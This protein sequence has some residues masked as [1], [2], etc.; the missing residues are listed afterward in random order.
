MTQKLTILEDVE[1][2]QIEFVKEWEIKAVSYDNRAKHW[3]WEYPG[4]QHQDTAGISF[5]FK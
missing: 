1:V 2:K 3:I 4:E 5:P